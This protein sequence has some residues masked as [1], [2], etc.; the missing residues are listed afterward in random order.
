VEPATPEDITRQIPTPEEL[1]KRLQ[2]P[3]ARIR[4]V[5]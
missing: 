2:S 3:P 5:G 4:K 1:Q